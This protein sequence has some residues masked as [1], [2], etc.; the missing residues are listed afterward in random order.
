[1]MWTVLKNFRTRPNSRLLMALNHELLLLDTVV[2]MLAAGSK[3]RGF[4]LSQGQCIFKG[5]KN[6]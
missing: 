2:I 1:V 3:V 5:D 6:S 4:K